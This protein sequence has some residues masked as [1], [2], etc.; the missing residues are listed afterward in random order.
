M[1]W[2]KHFIL[3]VLSPLTVSLA[4]LAGGLLCLWSARRPRTGRVL[5]MAGLVLL[6]LAGLGRVGRAYL[7]GLEGQY[8]PLDLSAQPA[9]T[10]AQWHYVLVLGGGHVSDPRLPVTSQIGGA[11]LYRLVEGIRLHRHLPG[12]RLILT[13]GPGLDV[14]PNAEVVAA[15]ARELGVPQEELIVLGKPRDT[16]E[17]AAC[18]REIV[19]TSPFVLVTS[20]FHMPRAMRVFREAGLRPVPAPTDFACP[21]GPGHDPSAFFPTA[22]GLGTTERALYEIMATAQ[23]AV[24]RW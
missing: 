24:R 23:E 18:V 7:A 3:L 15:V 17:E 13:G 16:R 14:V 9:A 5:C 2:L 22:G 4:L 11:S 12:S 20:A 10:V 21:A 19:G 6:T 1:V 8:A